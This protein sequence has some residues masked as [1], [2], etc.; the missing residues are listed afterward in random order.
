MGTLLVTQPLLAEYGAEVERRLA[1][2]NMRV[3]VFE[4]I[5]GNGCAAPADV[6]AAFLS[7][8]VMGT[9]SN[10]EVNHRLR[11]FLRLVCDAPQLRW[12]QLCS[13]GADRPVFQELMARG[14]QVTTASGA[15]SGEVAHTALAAMLAFAREVPVWIAARSARQ[16]M[17]RRDELAPRD[18]QGARA[19]VVGLGPIGLE[20]ARLCRAFGLH[21]TGV[22]RNAQPVAECDEVRP[23]T[24]LAQVLSSTDWLFLACPLTSETRNL[25]DAAMLARL[26]AHAHL[27]NVARGAIVQESALDRAL[28]EGRLAGAYSDVFATE[29]LPQDSPLWEAPNFMLS[30]HSA[31]SSQGF[32]PRTVQMFL[33]NLE[34]WLAGEPLRHP[35]MKS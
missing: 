35:A 33:A 28:R 17:P 18:L 31:G 24:D 27:I 4:E 2:G 9:S 16:W 11:D 5:L 26:P 22:R 8:D 14:V 12:L 20:I 13:T 15:S 19:C 6:E 10:P 7:T 32:P 1:S 29:P 23:T 25:I 3:A 30:A 34:R 21:V